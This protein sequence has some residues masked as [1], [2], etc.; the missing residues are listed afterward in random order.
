MVRH[1]VLS[2]KELKVAHFLRISPRAWKDLPFALI[3][4]GFLEGVRRVPATGG[5]VFV[6][7]ADIKDQLLSP[8]TVI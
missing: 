2:G 8:I 5:V 6:V 1:C 3:T 7:F 4:S